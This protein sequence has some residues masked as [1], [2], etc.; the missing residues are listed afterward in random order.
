M[1]KTLRSALLAG[2]ALAGLTATGHAQASAFEHKGFWLRLGLGY[3]SAAVTCDG[4]SGPRE[5]G[6]GGGLSLGGTINPHFQLGFE[7]SAWSKSEDGV[8]LSIGTGTLSGYF[9][10]GAKRRLYLKAGLGVAFSVA[11]EGSSSVT[12]TGPGGILGLGY[13]V[14]VSRKVALSP[15]ASWNYGSLGSQS[16]VGTLHEN[17][18]QVGLGLTFE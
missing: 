1:M 6:L 3:A 16:G 14:P 15:Y 18:F 7:S 5:N 10:P 9:Y 13:D 17:T 4:C 12:H 11:N 8:T 2:L